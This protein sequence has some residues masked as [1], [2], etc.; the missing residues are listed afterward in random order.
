MSK[1]FQMGIPR[2]HFSYIMFL[3]EV[4]IEGITYAGLWTYLFHGILSVLLG[5]DTK[6]LIVYSSKKKKI[7]SVY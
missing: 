1:Y 4:W 3:A 6:I 2:S 5:A 7:H